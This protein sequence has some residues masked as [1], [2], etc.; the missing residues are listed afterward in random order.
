MDRPVVS[1]EVANEAFDHSFGQ[2]SF[3]VELEDIKDVAGM[4]PIHSRQQL[5]AVEF[6]R[7][8]K[9]D[10]DIGEEGVNPLFPFPERLPSVFSA[11]GVKA[12]S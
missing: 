2:S 11:L 1:G 5:A 9:R 7:M 12:N 10:F 6:V 4:L 8:K 3:L